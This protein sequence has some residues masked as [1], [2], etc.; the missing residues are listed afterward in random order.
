VTGTK[1]RKNTKDKIIRNFKNVFENNK[2]TND[3]IKKLAILLSPFKEQTLTR[4]KCEIFNKNRW[5]KVNVADNNKLIKKIID[6]LN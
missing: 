2:C 3:K 4:G 5:E 1:L 6:Q